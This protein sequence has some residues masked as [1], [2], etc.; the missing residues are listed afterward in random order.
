[1]NDTFTRNIG[2][3]VIV[4]LALLAL[5]RLPALT[6]NAAAFRRLNFLIWQL[7]NSQLNADDYH[8]LAAGYYEGLEKNDQVGRG[9]EAD[10]YRMLGNFLR[11]EYKP[12]V[13]RTYEAGLR[14]TNSFGMQNPE[15]GIEKPPHTRRIAWLGD[16]VSLGPYGHDFIT[17]LES[18]LNREYLTS[19]THKYEILNFAVPGYVLVQEMDVALEKAPR[20][21]PDVYVAALTS[22]EIVGSRKH[23]ARLI[24]SGVDLK[25]DFLKKLMARADVRP[26]DHI[27]TIILKLKP[28]LPEMTEWSLKQIR[29]QAARDGAH[30][31]VVLVPAAME[32]HVTATDFDDLHAGA[33]KVG[34]P[35]IDLRDTFPS[36]DLSSLQ[37]VPQADIHPNARGHEMIYRN[38]LAKLRA[39]QDAWADIT[40]AP[41]AA[42]PPSR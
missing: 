36:G 6:G 28:F 41:N 37:V 7:H 22:Q 9:P 34:V 35:V 23:I 3:A 1:M 16:S 21:H 14:F 13:K 18:S 25:Y 38:L 26:T 19:E 29:D 40:G 39:R 5:D 4:L 2:R 11:F 32:P 17:L 31:I 20:F 8:A 10:D 30:L 15:Y 27:P 12:D 33:D 42:P 24:T